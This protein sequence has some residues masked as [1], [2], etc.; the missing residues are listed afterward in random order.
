MWKALKMRYGGTLATTLLGLTMRFDSY[1][2]HLDHTMKKHLRETSTMICELKA[3][4]N[5]LTDE[6]QVQTV[7]CSFLVFGRLSELN[8]Q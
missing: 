5:N 2:M 7:I 6:Q 4:R 3:T 8:P 1:N